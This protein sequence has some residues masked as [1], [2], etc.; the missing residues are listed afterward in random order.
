M[1]LLDRKILT[2][3]DKNARQSYSEIAKKIKSNKFTVR[4]R[5]NSL[6]KRNIIIGTRTS[7]NM[8]KLG[9]KYYRIHLRLQHI[10]TK[11][12]EN[13]T[14]I[15]KQ[16]KR[17]SWVVTCDGKHDII[18]ITHVKSEYELD[19][20]TNNFSNLFGKHI[21]DIEISNVLELVY[22]NRGYW[23]DKN[24]PREDYCV[25]FEKTPKIEKIDEY[26]DKI[27]SIL[28]KNARAS[29]SE[30]AEKVKLS[31][32]AVANRIKKL[33]KKGIIAKFFLL[34]NYE[35]VETQLYKSLFYTS[36][37][38]KSIIKKLAEIAKNHTY[39]QSYS[40]CV[41]PW[42]LEIDLEAKN[43]LHYHEIIREFRDN[44]PEIRYVESLYII[45]EVKF[46]P[47]PGLKK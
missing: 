4:N 44:I 29:C 41:G 21:L 31:S 28:S 19:E 17:L 25:G 26:D 34:V 5:I 8:T 13:I 39:V 35:N 9:Y 33:V 45:D 10:S 42:K 37:V 24:T 32:D 30:I 14:E 3:L 23:I 7:V 22:S 47:Y 46:D 38:N 18:V 20:I 6:I 1:D 40:H 27:L 2:E 36:A 16:D 12:I 15:L 11:I 43:H